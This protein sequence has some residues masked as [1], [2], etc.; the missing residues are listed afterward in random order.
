MGRRREDKWLKKLLE[1]SRLAPASEGVLVPTSE[2]WDPIG[3][4]PD[5]VAAQAYRALEARCP[6]R[7]SLASVANRKRRLRPGELAWLTRY[8][9]T[10]SL[11]HQLRAD[12]RLVALWRK[13]GWTGL[14][15][16]LLPWGPPV[17]PAFWR[18]GPDKDEPIPPPTL[19]LDMLLFATLGWQ[20]R[21][22]HGEVPHPYVGPPKRGTS[23]K[24]CP[25]HR[26]HGARLRMKR[27]RLRQARA[28]RKKRA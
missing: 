21:M 25:I 14:A 11:V 6:R 3:D 9:L 8:G 22:C 18:R 2:D 10:C 5:P 12:Q 7:I 24:Y 23:P 28:R 17:K 27:W 19:H 1:A 26:H 4:R 20:V 15:I 16:A 13:A